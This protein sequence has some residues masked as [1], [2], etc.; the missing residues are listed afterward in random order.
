MLAYIGGREIFS[1]R[2][3]ATT[4]GLGTREKGLRAVRIN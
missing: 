3:K 1:I 2:E 4:E